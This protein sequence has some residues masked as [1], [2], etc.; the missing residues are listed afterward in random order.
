M[1]YRHAFLPLCAVLLLAACDQAPE[2]EATAESEPTAVEETVAEV[3]VEDAPQSEEVAAQAPTELAPPPA[4]PVEAVV[5]QATEVM[6]EA[7]DSV[8]QTATEQLNA[9]TDGQPLDEAASALVESAAEDVT[10]LVTEQL[11]EGAAEAVTGLVAGLTG[12]AQDVA[13]TAEQATNE[14]TTE[15]VTE[16][17]EATQAPEAPAPWTS[18]FSPDV[19]YYNTSDAPVNAFSSPADADIIGTVAPGAGGFI[20]DCNEAMDWCE[21]PIDENG[22]LGWVNMNAF[23]GVAN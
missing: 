4:D 1:T 22:T 13:D 15:V 2:P 12:A 9:V 19:P 11:P 16:V 6:Q 7:V 21:L 10:A 17:V 18:S 14:A 20:V 8:A 23:G 3:V 5:E